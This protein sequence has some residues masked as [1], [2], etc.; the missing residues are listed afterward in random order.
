MVNQEEAKKIEETKIVEVK[1]QDVKK[2]VVKKVK[3]KVVVTSHSLTELHTLRQRL[4]EAEAGLTQH[5]HICLGEDGAHDCGLRISQLEV[6]THMD[7]THE[8][9]HTQIQYTVH[10]RSTTVCVGLGL[11]M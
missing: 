9:T 1:Q 7:A 8:R 11:C 4:E 2:G 3:K 10:P 6:H 5:I